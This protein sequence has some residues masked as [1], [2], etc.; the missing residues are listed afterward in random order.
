M[1]QIG[2]SLSAEP[3]QLFHPRLLAS[4]VL[5]S[6]PSPL[7]AVFNRLGNRVRRTR[8]ETNLVHDY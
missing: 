4:L 7:R 5:V 3:W 8:E 1:R 6:S 2:R